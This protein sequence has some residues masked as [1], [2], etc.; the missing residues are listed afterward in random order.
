MQLILYQTNLSN[1]V[2]ILS[3]VFQDL[4]ANS[5]M[6]FF[7]LT[8]LLRNSIVFLS[9]GYPLPKSPYFFCNFSISSSRF[10]LA[11]IEAAATTV[12]VESA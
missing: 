11:I 6:F 7:S 3:H 9:E 2:F 5:G 4:R 12:K 8:Q 1:V 10:T